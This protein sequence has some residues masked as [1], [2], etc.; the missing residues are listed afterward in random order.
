MG[1]EVITQAV[2]GATS[3]TDTIWKFIT[4]FFNLISIL[5][6]I[7]LLIVATKQ[8][9]NQGWSPEPFATQFGERIV[10]ADGVAWQDFQNL[11]VNQQNYQ[12]NPYQSTEGM[13]A[14]WDI[15]WFKATS[16]NLLENWHRFWHYT[17]ISW[18]L[19][20]NLWFIYLMLWFFYWVYKSMFHQSTGRNILYSVITNSFLQIFY[21][22]TKLFTIPDKLIETLVLI[23]IALVFF[24]I[25]WMLFRQEESKLAVILLITMLIFAGVGT[26][27]NVFIP[28]NQGVKNVA[29]AFI[30][31]KGTAQIIWYTRILY[32]PEVQQFVLNSGVLPTTNNTV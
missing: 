4:N 21:N 23:G 24:G 20:S 16:Y 32:T 12:T 26:A 8:S 15:S 17:T 27:I 31:Y 25:T 6:I 5:V 11:I 29:S 1:A 13:K 3:V 10:S 2:G 14:F 7:T 18:E 30:P 28:D 19:F 9:Y 22:I